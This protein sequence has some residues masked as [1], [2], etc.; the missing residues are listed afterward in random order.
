V[1]LYCRTTGVLAVTVGPFVA[2][3]V[4]YGSTL[5]E[6]I[7]N[8]PDLQ[9]YAVVVGILAL[10]M[11]FGIPALGAHH[12]LVAME[13]PRG[14]M[15]ATIFGTTI[16]LILAFPLILHYE[17]LGAAIALGVG[18]AC[19]TAYLLIVFRASFKKWKWKDAP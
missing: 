12:A 5:L 10:R 6:L 15:Q 11:L 4:A 3:A 17:V 14:T 16:S 7:Y 2:I 1:T 19:E 8:T 18:T 13:Y 9:A